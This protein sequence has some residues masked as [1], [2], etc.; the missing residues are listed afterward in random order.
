MNIIRTAIFSDDK[1]YRYRLERIFDEDLYK[2]AFVGVNPSIADDIED[3]KTITKCINYAKNWGYGGIVMVNL[4][5]L[6]STDPSLLKIAEN[7]IG[8]DND[9]HLNEVFNS[10]GTIGKIVCCWGENG[11]LFNRDKEVLKMIDEPYCLK[12]NADNSPAHPL[13]LA[14]DLEPINYLDYLK[15]KLNIK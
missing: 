2:V 13:Y 3:D 5:G 11:K 4:F 10:V 14:S 1:K 8:T 12:I 9:K 6:I 7:P 15:H